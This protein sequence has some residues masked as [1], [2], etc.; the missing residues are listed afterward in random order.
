MVN[1]GIRVGGLISGAFIDVHRPSTFTTIYVLDALAMLIPIG[2]LLGPLRHVRTQV[3]PTQETADF[4][5]GFG[6]TLLQPTIPAITND[7]APDHLRGRFNAISSGAFQAGAVAGPVAAGFL[8]RHHWNVQ[9]VV[10]LLVGCAAM[11][12]SALALERRISL[13][14]NGIVPPIKDPGVVGDGAVHSV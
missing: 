3:E 10:V 7:L 4:V 13:Q 11:A 1:L 14:V 5:F 9:Y 2:L 8:L 6:E 12:W